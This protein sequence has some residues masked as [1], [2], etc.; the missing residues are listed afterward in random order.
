MHNQLF[1]Q[2]YPLV[3]RAARVRLAALPRTAM[4][5]DDGR[6]L[7]QELM[8]AAWQALRHYDPARASLR[9]FVETIVSSRLSSLLRARRSQ[10]RLEPLQDHMAAGLD[11][12]PAVE[13]RIDFQRVSSQLAEPD[14]RLA[15]YLMNH[16]PTQAGRAFGISRS[17]IYQRLGRIRFAFENGG[18]GSI[19]RRVQ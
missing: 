10:P 17:T 19:T 1:A 6:D 11:G 4:D 15:I 3:R 2:A 16:S 12:I 8:V 18:F 14:C 7:E 9:T 13:F 5:F